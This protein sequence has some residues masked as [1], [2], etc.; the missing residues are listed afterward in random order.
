[1]SE[2]MGWNCGLNPSIQ[3]INTPAKR[4]MARFVVNDGRDLLS[5][6]HPSASLRGRAATSALFRFTA[7]IRR[8][9]S[10]TAAYLIVPQNAK[11]DGE[12]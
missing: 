4:W 6:H 2:R 8:L 11:H 5:I 7:R 12:D 1:M 9:A 10:V 3:F